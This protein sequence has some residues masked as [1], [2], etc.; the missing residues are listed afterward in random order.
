MIL[1]SLSSIHA[2]R[3]LP[4]LFS[5]DAWPKLLTRI[6]LQQSVDW[7]HS[8]IGAQTGQDVVMTSEKAGIAFTS[9][10]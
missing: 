6:L 3:S 8:L 9:D 1:A 5:M 10:E 7:C 2:R 4:Q